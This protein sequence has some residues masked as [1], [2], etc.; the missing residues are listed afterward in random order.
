EAPLVARRNVRVRAKQVHGL[1]D[2]VVEVERVSAAQLILIGAK[3]LGENAIPR[4]RFVSCRCKG[5]RVSEFV[6][7]PG[8]LGTRVRRRET[9]AVGL[10]ILNDSLEKRPRVGGVVDREA[11]HV[12]EA[13]RF[14]T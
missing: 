7:E 3:D 5:L 9:V 6:L 13:F 10:E 1:P 14:A 4:V 12:T 8:Y 2:E 11:G